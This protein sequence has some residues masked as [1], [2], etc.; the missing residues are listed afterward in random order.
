M[1]GSVKR[2]R[3]K[4]TELK[5]TINILPGNFGETNIFEYNGYAITIE[6]PNEVNSLHRVIVS[7][8]HGTHVTEWIEGESGIDKAKEFIDNAE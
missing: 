1:D 5:Q 6:P 8:L 2:G 4:S 3:K 7:T